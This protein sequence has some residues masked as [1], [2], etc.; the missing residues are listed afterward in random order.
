MVAEKAGNLS[1]IYFH[2]VFQSDAEK[3]GNLSNADLF[4]QSITLGFSKTNIIFHSQTLTTKF[5]TSNFPLFEHHFE[6][7]CESKSLTNFLL[8]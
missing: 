5:T 7:L 4:S 1:V 2:K 3:A 8:F 6:I